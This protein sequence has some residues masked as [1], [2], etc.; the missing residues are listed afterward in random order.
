MNPLAS[1]SGGGGLSSSSSATATSG[2]ALGKSGTGQKVVTFGG[3]PNTATGVLQN[4][5]V[6]IAGIAAL[7]LIFQ[8]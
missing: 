7:Y 3:N 5:V 8:R 6:L 4:P 1:F 2:D